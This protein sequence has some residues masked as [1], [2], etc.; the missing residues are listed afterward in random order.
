MNKSNLLP[1]P[2][3]TAGVSVR[4]TCML[5]TLLAALIFAPIILR[6]SGSAYD[7]VVHTKLAMQMLTTHSLLSPHFLLQA[8]IILFNQLLHVNFNT[9]CFLV[10]LFSIAG[11]A[12]LIFPRMYLATGKTLSSG[13]LVLGLMLVAPLP[14]LAPLDGHQYLGYIGINIY[15]NPTIL[16]LKPFALLLFTFA[17]ARNLGVGLKNRRP[18]CICILVAIGCTLTKPS[19]MIVF[20]PTL[21]IAACVPA[22][23]QSLARPVFIIC[24]IMLPGVLILAGQYWVTYSAQQLPGVYEGKSSIILAPLLVMSNFSSWL[25]VKFFLSISFP[26]AVVVGYIRRA[27]EDVRLCLAWLAFTIGAAYTYLLA[28]SGPRIFQGN[29]TWSGQITLFILFVVSLE[30]FCEQV[31]LS[32]RYNRASKF[33]FT[34]CAALFVLH[35]LSGIGYYAAEF[36]ANE[37]YW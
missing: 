34:L 4:P 10:V 32:G 7:Y 17:T 9:S 13:F 29:F 25:L 23:R 8:S 5:T 28:E 24:G 31:R 18:L 35:I 22:M 30:F 2:C 11:T 20:L 6:M 21:A 15:H 37:R 19:Y 26:L 16:L 27:L 1:T 12:A 36:I 3:P 33:I 14:L